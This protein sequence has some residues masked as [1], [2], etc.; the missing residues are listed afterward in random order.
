MF[1]QA[2]ASTYVWVLIVAGLI[3]LFFRE[4]SNRFH[5]VAWIGLYLKHIGKIVQ[6]KNPLI[7]FT[8]GTFFWISGA[9]ITFFMVLKL[10]QLIFLMPV[11]PRVSLLAIILKP[12]F[13]WRMLK[14]EVENLGSALSES[15]TK[16]RTYLSRMVSR[17]VSELTQEE[18]LESGIESLFE[19]LSDSV[20]APIFFF[21]IGGAPFAWLYRYANTADAMWGYRGPWE[22]AGKFTAHADDLLSWIP[23]RITAALISP[24]FF[25]KNFMQI[26]IEARKTSSPNG[27]WPM[28]MAALL[29]G[30]K[31]GKPGVYS[32]NPKGQRVTLKS[33]PL[34]IDLATRTVW[35]VFIISILSIIVMVI[36]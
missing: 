7:A 21:V 23:A 12:A 11:I 16:G 20:V 29:L 8:L 36:K 1:S 2:H 13:S 18:V 17:D 26:K 27:G 22:H 19:N 30:I 10:E 32:L 25:I 6:R 4:P 9:A 35:L 24:R 33:I 28:G 15:L 3:D 34:A 14:S 31:L 5:P